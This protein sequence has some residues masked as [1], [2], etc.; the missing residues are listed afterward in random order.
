MRASRD[1]LPHI[2]DAAVIASLIILNLLVIA[3]FLTT[4]FSSQP[5]NND[6]TYIGMSR[7]FRDRAWSWNSLQYGG[8]PFHYLYPPLFHLLVMAVPVHSLG[9]AYHFVSGASYAV[10]P[11]AFYIAAF[12]LFRSRRLAAALAWLQSFSPTVL[13]Y[14]LPGFKAFAGNYRHGPWNFV[15]MIASNESAHTL[16]L[17]LILL[18]LAAA[19]RDRWMTATLLAAAIFLLN[20]A[21]IIG[22]LMVLTAIAVARSRDLGY[23]RAALRVAGVAGI[24]YGLAAFWVTPDCI[25]TTKLLDRVVLRH[26]QPSTPWT[27]I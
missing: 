22:L 1:G 4:D 2:Y 25:Y 24:G 6:Y 10:V 15:A 18:V 13:Y 7:M 17:A 26:I 5:W 21:G 20:W 27:G 3:P 9:R 23:G 19:W 12:Q 14:L 8:A 11:A 16:S